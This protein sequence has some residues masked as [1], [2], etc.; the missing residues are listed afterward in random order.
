M[1]SNTNP[2]Y[3]YSSF[4]INAYITDGT[5]AT[6]TDQPVQTS[7]MCGAGATNSVNSGVYNDYRGVFS[8]SFIMRQND[9]IKIN[10]VS[11][12]VFNQ[13]A[14]QPANTFLF[15]GGSY[16]DGVYASLTCWEVTGV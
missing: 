2:Q 10:A 6:R 1:L 16:V 4:G 9:I 13:S 12:A 8:C 7:M 5:G 11:N 3:A 15:Q 14:Q